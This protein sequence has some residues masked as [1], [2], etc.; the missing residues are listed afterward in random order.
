M[1]GD[2]NCNRLPL[3]SIKNEFGEDIFPFWYENALYY[4]AELFLLYS[5]NTNQPEGSISKQKE[6]IKNEKYQ[7]A[8]NTTNKKQTAVVSHSGLHFCPGLKQ[9]LSMKISQTI[10]TS[11]D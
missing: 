6:R 1:M 9:H 8:K 4:T 3:L 7:L 11:F 2:V 10:N 5:R